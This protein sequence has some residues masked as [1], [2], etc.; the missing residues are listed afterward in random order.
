MLKS[1]SYILSIF[2][3]IITFIIC[4]NLLKYILILNK[5]QNLFFQFYDFRA[6]I[7]YFSIVSFVIL[8]LGLKV[9]EIIAVS[10]RKN[11]YR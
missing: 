7:L 1:L 6:D 8:I 2:F 10:E 5:I 11:R 3:A 9:Q 4:L